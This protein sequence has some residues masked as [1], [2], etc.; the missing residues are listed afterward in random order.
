[1]R[2]TN[3][4]NYFRINNKKIELKTLKQKKKNSIFQPYAYS[5]NYD[6]LFLGLGVS[7]PFTAERSI[8]D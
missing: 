7:L 6:W 3:Y 2:K 5:L 1:M 8:F 4:R